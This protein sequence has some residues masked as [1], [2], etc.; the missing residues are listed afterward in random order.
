MLTALPFPIPTTESEVRDLSI[1]H[2]V[3][4]IQTSSIAYYE[5]PEPVISDTLF[6]IATELLRDE[7]PDHPVLQAVGAPT[8]GVKV[9]HM[10]PMLSLIKETTD[11]GLLSW[12]RPLRDDSDEFVI[13]TKADGSSVE[14][15]IIKGKLKLAVTRGNGEVGEDVTHSISKI[16]P[17]DYPMW[18]DIDVAV[19]G[20]VVLT[21]EDWAIADPGQLTNPRNVGN[22][23]VRRSDTSQAHLLTFIA[24]D[25][26]SPDT[27]IFTDTERFNLK[28]LE[29]AGFN[30]IDSIFVTPGIIFRTLD[31][32][33]DRR[34]SLAYDIDGA[35]IKP[36]NIKVGQALGVTGGRPRGQ[37]AFKWKSETAFT[38]LLGAVITVGHTGVIVPTL[39]LKPV[40]LGG[41]TVKSAL[42]NNFAEL[43][44]FNLHIGDTVEIIRAGEIIP[45]VLGVHAR[46][47]DGERIGTPTCCP[48]CSGNVGYRDNV[49]GEK[50]VNLYCL[51]DDC[52]AKSLGKIKRWLKSLDILGIG[53]DLLVQITT[54]GVVNTVADLYRLDVKTLENLPM[55]KGRVGTSRATAIVK[56]IQARRELTLIEFLG[57]L[58]IPTLGKRKV[59]LIID[60]A[61]KYGDNSLTNLQGWLDTDSL[62]QLAPSIS[63]E[64]TVDQ[65]SKWFKSS[66]DLL[67]DVLT[68]VNIVERVETQEKP[69]EARPGQMTVLLTGT[70]DVPKKEIH[71]KVEAAGHLVA[72]DWGKGVT[73]LV[74][75]NP[76]SQSSKSKKA[77]AAGIPVISVET[78]NDLLNP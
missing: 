75:S 64:G 20:E 22:G 7:S 52:S 78:L 59:K 65:I 35:V 43:D 76:A 24:F 16:V 60:A 42:A 50:S 27:D 51:N 53:D 73:H 70:F 55:G 1:N 14:L 54:A 44:R 21:H 47:T 9:K 33:K 31:E 45:K 71:A 74:Q 8:D 46:S 2:L 15:Q 12:I 38:D 29:A 28:A 6:D 66:G 23:I 48:A 41:V 77:S 30:V 26:A 49:N 5:T 37:R 63:I 4:L 10:M 67:V 40:F 32:I 56:N 58:G 18:K 13:E 72:T 11:E 39:R 36:N 17:L 69:K 68:Q 57:S 62:E 25:I 61:I 3:I 34:A 19:R